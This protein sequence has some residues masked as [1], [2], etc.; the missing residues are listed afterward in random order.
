M[1]IK[2][3]VALITGAA[4]RVG[5]AIAI[6]LAGQGCHIVLNYRSSAEAAQ[7]TQQELEAL[8]VQVLPVQAD[9]S[10]AIAVESM[11][12]QAL[13]YF[14]QVDILVNN[15]AV[16]DKTPFPEM[17]LADWDKVI[18]VNLRGPFLCARAVAP[19]ML[20]LIE[21]VIIN[22]TDLAGLVP[23]PGMLA[24][25]IAKA[26]LISLT[27]SLA[28]ELGPNIRVNGIAPGPIIPPP[29]YSDKMKQRI[30]QRTLLK[31]WGEAD[32][33]A[34][35]VQFLIENDYITGEIIRVDAG[36]I[37][38]WRHRPPGTA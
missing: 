34:Q 20:T 3:K 31:R 37:I 33:V 9:V 4:H 18:N 2:N 17:S 21:G 29:D 12:D 32:H 25:S 11:V 28:L 10:D 22:I 27:E 19:T 13:D 8:G 14:G 24:H 1:Q 30:A 16:F 35:T 26:G 15:A 23:I 6:R 38:G 7:Q 36:E 5:K